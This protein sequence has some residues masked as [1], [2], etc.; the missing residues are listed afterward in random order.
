[1]PDQ[2]TASTS[3]TGAGLALAFL[4][5]AGVAHA[6]ELADAAGKYRIDP[7]SHISF[8]VGQVAGGGIKGDFGKFRGTF[9][10]DG[11]NIGKSN[12]DFTLLPASVRTGETRVETFLRSDA[13]FDVANYPEI[14]FRSTSV[15]RTGPDSARIEG[16][17]TARG[18]THKAVFNATVERR[19]ARNIN[20]HVQGQ[21]LRSLYGMDAGTPIY[22]NLVNFNMQL[23]GSR[24]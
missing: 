9:R 1:M 19:N 15:T 16:N 14:V 20:F 23:Q 2:T 8:S 6:D 11:R 5:L 18:R 10:I 17:L 13:I 24:G 12:V 4:I 21:V 7:S 22:S 3:M